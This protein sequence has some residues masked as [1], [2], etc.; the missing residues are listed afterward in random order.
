MIHLA[1]VNQD[2]DGDN[3]RIIYNQRLLGQYYDNESR[4]HY[5]YYRYYQPELGRYITSDPIGFDGGIN[6]YSYVSANPLILRDLTGLLGYRPNHPD[7]R[8]GGIPDGPFGPVCGSGHNASWI[9]DW[10]WK[11]AC[12]NHDD[13]Y[14]KCESDRLRCDIN[15]LKDSGNIY[16][17]IAVRLLGKH[18]YDDA[19]KKC[20]KC[21][22]TN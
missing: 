9:P 12:Q 17:F 8:R 16:Y 2:P 15:L 3:V 19:Q 21:D 5:N 20:S 4:L 6:T 7:L 1:V 14:G 13:C 18:P 11:N 22:Q 10:I